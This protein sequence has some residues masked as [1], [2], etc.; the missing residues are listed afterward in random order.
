[1]RWHL[2]QAI[3]EIDPAGSAV[4][5]AQLPA[6]NDGVQRELLLLEMMAQTGGLALGVLD[7]FQSDLV[8]AKVDSA[9]FSVSP[10][11]TAG[12]RIEARLSEVRE[13]GAWLDASVKSGS[14]IILA[15]ARFLLARVPGLNKNSS[16][17]VSF[18]RAFMEG[19]QVRSKILKSEKGIS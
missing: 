11:D 19:Y 18:H 7:D 3:E 15:Q 6:A 2:L 5:R 10:S 14:G 9:D 8:F 1:M 4:T 13:E 17:P 16:T 12:L